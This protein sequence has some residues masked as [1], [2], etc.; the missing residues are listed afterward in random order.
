M[1]LLLS[2]FSDEDAKAQ[3]GW[4]RASVY[5][6]EWKFV[7]QALWERVGLVLFSQVPKGPESGQ[8]E[9]VSSTLVAQV[10]FTTG[11]PS[12]PSLSFV[13]L[14]TL[15]ESGRDVCLPET[16][17]RGR[18]CSVGSQLDRSGSTCQAQLR[19]SVFSRRRPPDLRFL[20][21]WAGLAIYWE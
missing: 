8:V 18:A 9:W 11:F 13:G 21:A 16:G 7:C 5:K 3:K 6:T 1:M 14:W 10:S 2:S 20:L 19:S 17:S 4:E 12:S 15:Y